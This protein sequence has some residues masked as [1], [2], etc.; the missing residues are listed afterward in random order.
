MGSHG[1]ED[2]MRRPLSR[3]W[4]QLSLTPFEIALLYT[5]VSGLWIL[6]SDYIVYRLVSDPVLLTRLHSAKSWFYL[7]ATGF[8]LY[9]LIS[10]SFRAAS[11]S[12]EA[13]S[14][15]EAR[16]RSLF[17][18]NHSVMLLID[19]D[20]TEI[21]DANPAA[22]SFYG[23]SRAEL[24]GKRITDINTLPAE[25]ARQEMDQASRQQRRHFEFQHRLAN[26]DIR[27]VEVHTGPIEVHGR[28]LLYSIIYDVTDRRRIRETIRKQNAELQEQARLLDLA[29]SSI[30]AWDM[31]D[32]VC[33]WNQEA[34]ELYG[35]SKVEAMGQPI[36]TLLQTQFPQ[37]LEAIKATVFQ[38][39]HWEGELVHTRKDGSRII[40]AS[41]WAVQ[42]DG[43]GH[44][45]KVLQVNIDVTA[46]KE[47]EQ[48]Q[49]LLAEAGRLLSSARDYEA[50][51]NAVLQVALPTL[52]DMCM[53][54]L[55]QEDG[56]IRR[57]VM[58]QEEMAK[59]ELA[60][61]LQ[62]FPPGSEQAHPT[63]KV[64]QTGQPEL[65]PEVT[66][67][68]LESVAYDARHLQILRELK[69]SS[70][71]V[72]PLPVQGRVLG[73]IIFIWVQPGR[74]YG[75]ADLALAEEL[76]RRAALALE[77]ARL[78][79]AEQAA[80]QRLEQTAQ[81]LERTVQRLEQLQRVTAALSEA[82]TQE[83]VTSVVVNQG[84][85]ALEAGAGM[86]AL[87]DEAGRQMEVIAQTGYPPDV[88]E[89]WQQFTLD[90]PA[91]L[92]AAVKSS[93]PVYVE[94][95]ERLA[96]L[97][98]EVAAQKK[99]PYQALASLPLAVH[100]RVLG[101][102]GLS[103]DQPRAFETDDRAFILALAQ[104]CAQAL[105]RAQLYEAEMKARQRAEEAEAKLLLSL[106]EKEVLL[107]EVNH[108]VKNNL[109]A[110]S[111]L[112]YL[113]SSYVQSEQTRR[114]L[115]D[116]QDRVKSIA[117]IH[118]KLYQT[119]NFV[120]IDFPEYVRSLGNELIRSY[121]ARGE[122]IRL[123]VKSD[124]T[125]LE[126]DTAVTLGIIAN[127]LISNA[128]KHAFPEEKTGEIS[129]ELR[130]EPDGRLSLAV[131][132]DG[133]GFPPE[134][135][136]GQTGSLGLQLVQMLVGHLQGEV[137]L[138]RNGGTKVSVTVRPIPSE[139]TGKL[140]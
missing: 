103:F 81:R 43:Q 99:T 8:L 30:I 123:V 101:G 36:H 33:Y 21:V 16:Y 4:P 100:G 7:L 129:I 69:L 44:P 80:R 76:A 135:E 68:F 29:Y 95:L 94:S 85:E 38:A 112:L 26:N 82:L 5:L 45:E 89:K 17:E 51:L 59:S 60:Y 27:D 24:T 65:T 49:R 75:E 61:L 109:Q 96:D 62:D 46:L 9:L 32:R 116:A 31:E 23:Y 20:T 50:T 113:Q 91:P 139:A 107:R 63:W 77:N 110:V 87:L 131:S 67:A 57:M 35:W 70:G 138:E 34:E 117:L 83:E 90:A 74:R 115:Q 15:S 118:E 92:T 127:E 106:Q 37:P 119:Q 3:R 125:P 105:Q 114:Q 133:I 98:P 137:M 28:Q 128:L 11:R 71:M 54:D 126:V 13:L 66:E 1:E 120:E 124:G 42:R 132:D 111:N 121:R 41:R 40:V 58:V 48:A 73:T 19:P 2:L 47:S 10:R 86:I 39:G 134:Q 14:E 108:R 104:Q 12:E 97:F 72:V 84:V 64:L 55:L 88:M 78:F 53:V 140:S 79:Q 6:S 122:Q 102:I 136:L 56:T 130:R 18:N 52:A 22:C 93:R 25:E